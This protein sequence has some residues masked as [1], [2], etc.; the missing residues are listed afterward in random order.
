[1]KP[2][3]ARTIRLACVV[4][5]AGTLA[6]CNLIETAFSNA[7]LRGMVPGGNVATGQLDCWLVLEFEST[8]EGIDPKDVRVRF[9]SMALLEPAEFDWAYIASHDRLAQG[10]R[11]GSGHK[12]NEATT[13]NTDPPLGSPM[14][15]RFP[16]R[17]RQRIDDMPTPLWLEAQLYWG[18]VKQST[19]RRTIEHVY[20]RGI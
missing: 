13:P 6:G 15:V 2:A 5:L 1:M 4:A 11:F 17:A 8:P 19:E 12:N 7:S 10:Q 18:G 20:S 3:M 14:K 16:L 9:E